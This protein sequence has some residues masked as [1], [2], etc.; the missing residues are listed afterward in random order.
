MNLTLRDASKRRAASISPEIAFVN[1]IEKRDAEAA[2]PLGEA[3]D[4]AKVGFDEPRQRRLVAVALDAEAE[5]A[6]FLDGQ[7]RQLRD[8]PQVRCERTRSLSPTACRRDTRGAYL[9]TCR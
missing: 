9:E 4:E 8:L 1:E 5:V 7:A 3:D 2:I 6:L